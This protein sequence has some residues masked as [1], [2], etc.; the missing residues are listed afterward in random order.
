MVSFILGGLGSDYDLFVTLVN[1]QVD[2]L[3]IEEFYGHLL[4]HE[5]RL[6]HNLTAIDLTVAGAN[7]ASHSPSYRGDVTLMVLALTTL[8]DDTQLPT[9]PHVSL[10]DEDVIQP[11]MSMQSHMDH[12]QIAPYVRFATRLAIFHLIAVLGLTTAITV[13]LSLPPKHI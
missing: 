8:L 6:D 10:V 4:G 11:T 13:I 5:Q 3:S 2:P 12:H 1:T 9:A 7:T